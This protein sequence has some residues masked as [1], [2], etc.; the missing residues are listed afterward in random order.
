[1]VAMS[2]VLV[3]GVAGLALACVCAMWRKA[4][5]VQQECAQRAA[6]ADG[7]LNS[8]AA[9]LR[10]LEQEVTRQGIE[11]EDQSIQLETK[12]YWED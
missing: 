10:R 9:Q 7:R 8:L 11:L 6:S 3:V 12:S 1:M 2:A 5:R 4:I